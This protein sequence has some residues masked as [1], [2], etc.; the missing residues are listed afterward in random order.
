VV[1][2]VFCGWLEV[3]KPRIDPG[4]TGAWLRTCRGLVAAHRSCGALRCEY[5]GPATASTAFSLRVF[6]MVAVVIRAVDI[7][8]VTTRV[9]KED[10]AA[11]L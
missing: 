6:E 5:R 11:S 3:M 1:L 2:C 9:W 7:S 10:A 8:R 4:T